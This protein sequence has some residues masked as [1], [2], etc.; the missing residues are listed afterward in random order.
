MFCW[1]MHIDMLSW[2]KY[3]LLRVFSK[4][5]KDLKSTDSVVR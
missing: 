5:D 2:E 1:I 3:E 4:S